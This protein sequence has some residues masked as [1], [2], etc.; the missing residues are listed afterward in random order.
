MGNTN[1]KESRNSDILPE[2][3]ITNLKEWKQLKYQKM[4]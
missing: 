1:V 3:V 4:K 2:N